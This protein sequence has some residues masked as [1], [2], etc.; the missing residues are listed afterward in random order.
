MN[1]VAMTEAEALKYFGFNIRA[2]SLHRLERL[3]SD[4]YRFA[5]SDAQRDRAVRLLDDLMA[6][7]QNFQE[8]KPNS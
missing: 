8:S 6:E 1:A 4:L 5:G 3:R 2:A 7:K